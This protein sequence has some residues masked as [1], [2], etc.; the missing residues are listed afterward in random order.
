MLMDG[1]PEVP[2]GFGATYRSESVTFADRLLGAVPWMRGRVCERLRESG[3]IYLVP[4]PGTPASTPSPEG[5]V[6][7]WEEQLHYDGPD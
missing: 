3:V 4:H 2:A 6:V 7:H 1:L 5:W